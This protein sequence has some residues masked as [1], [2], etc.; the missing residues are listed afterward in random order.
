MPAEIA[1]ALWAELLKVR[2]SRAPMVTVAAFTM[3]GLVGGLFMFVL[4]DPG[5]RGRWAC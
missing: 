3:A 4:Q 5:A 2:R 1:A